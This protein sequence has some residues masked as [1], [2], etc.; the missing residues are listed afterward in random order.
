MMTHMIKKF[1]KISFKGIKSL[2]FQMQNT[3]LYLQ[4]LFIH[5]S[6]QFNF[7]QYV[8]NKILISHIIIAIY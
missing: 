2:Q 4:L 7:L 5:N 3:S 1:F 6:R 8:V